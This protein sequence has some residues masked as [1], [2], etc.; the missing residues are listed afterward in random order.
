MSHKVTGFVSTVRLPSRPLWIA[1]VATAASPLWPRATF[2]IATPKGSS[3]RRPRNNGIGGKVAPR[4][5]RRTRRR[6]PVWFPELG[7]AAFELLSCVRFT[8]ISRG[9]LYWGGSIVFEARG[10]TGLK[11]NLESLSMGWKIGHTCLL[12]KFLK[13]LKSADW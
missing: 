2:S 5:R 9:D 3:R 1:G 8:I 4:R 13:I 11:Q 12:T 7:W 10:S 6:R